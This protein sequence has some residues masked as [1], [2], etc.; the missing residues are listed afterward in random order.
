VYRACFVARDDKGYC[1]ARPAGLLSSS[2]PRATAWGYYSLAHCVDIN[3]S[4][5]RGSGD[6]ESLLLL[7]PD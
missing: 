7:C 1:A 3:V 2:G 5:A 4:A 6:A